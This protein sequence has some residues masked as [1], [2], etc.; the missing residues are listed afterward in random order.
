MPEKKPCCS[1][2]TAPT[3]IF[4]CSGG[5]DVGEISDRTARRLSRE[6]LG[7]MFC[8]AGVGGHVN[9]ILMSTEAAGT[10]LVIDGCPVDCARKTLEHAGFDTFLHV[11]VTD[12]GF[13]KGSSPATE[14]RIEAVYAKGSECI[15]DGGVK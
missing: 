6:G 3:L 1:C 7:K 11:R 15:R 10:I 5:A 2:Q 4:S 9:N 8:L 13:T 14:D 12:C